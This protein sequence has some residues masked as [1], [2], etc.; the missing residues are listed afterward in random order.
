M[1]LVPQVTLQ[2]FDKWEVDFVGPINPL[3]KRTGAR[4]IITATD[5]LNRWVE[6]TPVIDCTTTT[7][8][9]LIFETIVMRFGCPRILMSD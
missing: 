6:A 8:G 2:P 5:Y 7:I 9:R 4:Y 1:P 3:G